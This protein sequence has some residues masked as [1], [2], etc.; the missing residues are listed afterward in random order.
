MSLIPR[1]SEPTDLQKL[2]EDGD[3]WIYGFYNCPADPRL[4]VRSP[5][6]FKFSPNFAHRLQAW[7]ILLGSIGVVACA[8]GIPMVLKAAPWVVYTSIGLAMAGVYAIQWWL[9]RRDS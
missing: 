6:G 5:F 8:V 7:T 4:V 1:R 2:R 9:A 3:N